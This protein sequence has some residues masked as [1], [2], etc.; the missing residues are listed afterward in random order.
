MSA[1]NTK[2]LGW[3]AIIAI[4]VGVAFITGLLLGFIGSIFGLSTRWTTVGLG[5]V[6]GVVAASLVAQR[7]AAL[8]RQ[9]SN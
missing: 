4:S 7:R 2:P 5:A 1:D 3:V 8:D 6:V 9:K